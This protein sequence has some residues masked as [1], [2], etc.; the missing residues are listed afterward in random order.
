MNLYE[1]LED[2]IYWDGEKGL[3]T[4]SCR[5]PFESES[6]RSLTDSKPSQWTLAEVLP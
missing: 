3:A 1:Y 2:N 6:I 5:Q 4:V